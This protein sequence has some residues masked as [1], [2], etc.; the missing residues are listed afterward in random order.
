MRQIFA[1]GAGLCL[2]IMPLADQAQAN[3]AAPGRPFYSYDS[4]ALGSFASNVPL[5][6][7]STRAFRYFL[8]NFPGVDNERWYRTDQGLSLI[9]AE[10]Q[11]LIKIYFSRKGDFMSS[12]KYYGRSEACTEIRRIASSLFPDYLID[13]VTEKFDGRLLVYRVN[14]S[15]GT[16]TKTFEVHNGEVVNIEDF[17]N[18]GL[19]VAQR[20]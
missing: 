14:M 6:E 16:E 7:I 2:S 8:K 12:L 20:K 3:S 1:F 17:S 11:R 5:N 19:P 9:F 18:L 10:G 15:G 4:T 13:I